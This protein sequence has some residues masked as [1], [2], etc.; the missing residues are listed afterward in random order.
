MYIYI[1]IYTRLMN[2]VYIHLYIY[3][4]LKDRL[5]CDVDNPNV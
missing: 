5:N 2:G 4:C 1:Y 3:V